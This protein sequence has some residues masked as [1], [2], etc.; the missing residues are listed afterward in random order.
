[1][2]YHTQGPH[3]Y[4]LMKAGRLTKPNVKRS[5][6]RGRPVWR[7]VQLCR[8]RG[9][10]CGAIIRCAAFEAPALEREFAALYSRTGAFDPAGK[11]AAGNAA[12]GLLYDPLGAS[13]D[14][15]AGV[16]LSVPLICWDRHRRRG[17][18][19][20]GVLEEPRSAAG[21]VTSPR[22]QSEKPPNFAMFSASNSRASHD[23]LSTPF[24]TSAWA[25]V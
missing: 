23:P 8:S 22:P 19:P 17:V 7:A 14:G 20:F 15:A 18:G 10:G 13:F 3:N 25:V 12:A 11:A 16:R 5:A 21:K 2:H 4:G 24:Q 1:M 6:R 9:V